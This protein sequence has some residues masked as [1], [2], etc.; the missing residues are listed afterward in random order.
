[1]KV[2]IK[3]INGLEGVD[4]STL[5]KFFLS[6]A[7][8]GEP[9][10]CGEKCPDFEPTMLYFIDR[11]AKKRG[12]TLDETNEWLAGIEDVCPIAAFKILL[13]EIALY[14]DEKYDDHISNSPELWGF[15]TTNGRIFKMVKPKCYKHFAGF[16][17]MEDA[18][19]AC[20]IMRD[21]IKALFKDA[22]EK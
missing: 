16:R 18:K 9:C 20:H 5:I 13:R 8:S 7:V 15:S 17:T 6:K 3:E 22:E 4:L 10:E 2:T 12:S 1:M 11:I 21:K 14:L 19:Y